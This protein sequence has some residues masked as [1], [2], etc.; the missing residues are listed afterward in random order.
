[1]TTDARFVKHVNQLI[2]TKKVSTERLSPALSEPI[3]ACRGVG[4]ANN[5]PAPSDSSSLASPLKEIPNTREYH[6][7][8]LIKSSDGLFVIESKSLK[9]AQFEDANGNQVKL[10]FASE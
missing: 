7:P 3:A 1:M 6:E 9:S 5:P 8:E 10:E 2:E 4:T